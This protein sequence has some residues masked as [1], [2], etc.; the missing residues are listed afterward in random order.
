[1]A[2]VYLTAA[3]VAGIAVARLT[4]L[5]IY[6]WA[7]LA[8]LPAGLL[9]IW[10]RDP[11]LRRIHLCLLFFIL[12]ALRCTLAIPAFDQQCRVPPG[13]SATPLACRNDQGPVLLEGAVV[14]PPEVRDRTVNIR[15]SVTRARSGD[16]WQN[17]SG[18]A[19]VQAPRETDVRYGDRLQVFAEPATPSESPEFSYKEYLARQGIHSLIRTYGGGIKVLARDEGDP[20][21]T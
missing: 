21:H 20:F 15:L 3:W 14:D 1:M 17:V 2:L 18:L 12:G 13:E 6:L 8:A 16:E 7:I 9:L 10:W 19:L 5:P 4:S 11:L